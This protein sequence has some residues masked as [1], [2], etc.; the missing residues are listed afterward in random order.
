MI[1]IRVDRIR[2]NLKTLT[3]LH[4]YGLLKKKKFSTN[5]SFPSSR[6]RKE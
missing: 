6:P 3:S 5:I 4:R 1:K 2:K